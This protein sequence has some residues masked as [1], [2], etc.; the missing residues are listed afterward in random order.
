M[1][2]LVALCLALLA[3]LALAACGG[4]DRS[5]D[6]ATGGGGSSAPA[7]DGAAR[8]GGT[9][10]IGA[11]SGIPQ[12]NPVLLGTAWEQ[13]LV[14]LLWDGLTKLD[15]VGKVEPDLATSWRA[16]ADSKT[17]TFELRDGVRF[18]NGTAL[19]SAEVVKALDYYL[20]P[21][22]ATQWKTALAPIKDVKADGPTQ[23]VFTLKTPNVLLPNVLANIMVVDVASLKTINRD[24]AVTGPYKVSEF[25]PEDHVTLVRNDAY[26]GDPSPLDE[27]RLVK[28]ADSTAAVTS[29][30]SG[31]LDALWSIP[32]SDVAQLENDSSLTVVKPQIT[33]QYVSWEYD[34]T[35]PPFD[36]VRVRKAVA[37][38]LD[39]EA[40]LKAAYYGQ[41]Q[42]S[43]TNTPLAE[44]S[45]FFGGDL[46]EYDYDL[47]KAKQ[48]FDAADVHSFT[49][50]GVAGQYPEWNTSAQILQASL[51]KIGVT[52]KIQN[53]ELS[54]WPAKFYPAGRSFP[55]LLVPNF[56][57]FPPDP[58]SQFGFLRAG[59]CECNWNNDEF[60]STID[61]ALG[62]A[63]P[64]ARQQL[65]N[66]AQELINQQ[67]PI[68]APVQ[69]MTETAT[70]RSVVG[71]WVDGGGAPHL[72]R[73]A[74]SAE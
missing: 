14:P 54:N 33:S 42:V 57:S 20:A 48:L 3:V 49:W 74:L 17:W 61:E 43:T 71:L 10:T 64:G 26:F 69:S 5:T 15:R 67:V 53:T 30:R 18:S 22:T 66:K 38:A 50:W 4:S 6:S 34:M 19:T 37:Y 2:R 68:I 25:V 56:Q 31:D 58:A 23:V 52:M 12:L 41:G 11:A 40:I 24:P 28:A 8:E 13:V 1:K 36:D 44:N 45:S 73:A 65:W 29:L 51:K 60:E 21:D 27:I 16:S 7:D 62:T 72:E 47:D 55:G 59:R 39:R 70:K 32:S 63:D 35:T 46:V 9:L